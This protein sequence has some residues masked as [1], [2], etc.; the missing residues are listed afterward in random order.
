MEICL[1][2][3]QKYAEN[4]SVLN[5]LIKVSVL[6]RITMLYCDYSK[7][8]FLYSIIICF[9]DCLYRLCKTVKLGFLYGGCLIVKHK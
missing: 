1:Y 6:D 2:D 5:R 9:G 8:G 4:K 3:K 7:L